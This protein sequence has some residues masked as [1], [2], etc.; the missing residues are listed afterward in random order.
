MNFRKIS[1]A[2]AAVAALAPAVSNASSERAAMDACARAFASSLASPGAT[3]PPYTVA[4]RSNQYVGSLNEFFA[5][6]YTFELFANNKKSGLAIARASCT[7]NTHGA[8]V[9][10]TPIPLPAAQATLAA[11][12]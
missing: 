3:A 5:R 2:A 12:R 6:E 11:Q 7:T 10:L 9:A 1:L 8:V 4:Y